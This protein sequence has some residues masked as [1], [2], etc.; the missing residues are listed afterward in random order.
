MPV[1]TRHS[2]ELNDQEEYRNVLNIMI[3]MPDQRITTDLSSNK[4]ESQPVSRT[5]TAAEFSL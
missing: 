1:T 3:N 2:N 4:K 5:T